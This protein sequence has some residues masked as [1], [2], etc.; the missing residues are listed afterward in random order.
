MV[1]NQMHKVRD[2]TKEVIDYYEERVKIEQRYIK[3]LQALNRKITHTETMECVSLRC[4][5]VCSLKQY[6][7]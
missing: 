2:F 1:C 5:C 7:A 4:C 6:V 3:D